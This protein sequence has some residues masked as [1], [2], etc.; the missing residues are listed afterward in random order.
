MLE[1][2]HLGVSKSMQH[3]YRIQSGGSRRESISLLFQHLVADCILWLMDTSTIFKVQHSDL[4]S[5]D[6]TSSLSSLSS[7]HTP[8]LKNF[9]LTNLQIPLAT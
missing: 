2:C 5:H 8:H 1:P 6:H 3:K 9:D 4:C 7:E